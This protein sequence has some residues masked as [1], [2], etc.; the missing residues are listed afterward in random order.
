MSTQQIDSHARALLDRLKHVLDLHLGK[1]AGNRL[2]LFEYLPEDI[3]LSIKQQGLLTPFLPAMYGGVN[4]QRLLEEVLRLAG[5][6]G[7]SVT[8][9]VGIEGALVVQPLTHYGSPELVNKVLPLILE[10]TGGGL[11]ITEPDV[12]GSAIARNMASWYEV[13]EDG[14]LRIQAT[15]YWQGNSQNEFL[16]VAAKEK[17]NGKLQKYINLIFV[18]KSHIRYVPLRSEGLH[19]VRYAVNTIEGVLP[20]ENLIVLSEVPQKNLREFQSLFIRSRLQFIG[21]THG[22]IERVRQTLAEQW[23]PDIDFVYREQQEI[24]LRIQVSQLLYNFVCDHVSPDTAVSDRLLEANVIKSLGS[25]ITYEAALIAQKLMGA[26]GYEE[27]HSVSQIVRDIRPFTLF[28]GPN[29]MLS[30]EI[31]DQFSRQ[32]AAE[33]EAGVAVNKDSSLYQRYLSDNRFVY[34]GDK[35]ELEKVSPVISHFLQQNTLSAIGSVQKVFAGRVLAKL[36]VLGRT[37]QQT[38]RAFL[39]REISKDILNF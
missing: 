8:L 5:H 7:A 28:E 9:R 3:W 36:F 2:S 26:K 11:A 1:E 19:A 33:K 12:S 34:V 14:R 29:D 21:M 17:K 15:K 39:I 32:T 30:S 31:F 13:L 27:G 22:V 20:A 35:A 10:G 23:L 38:V 18:P 37:T 6:Y 16:L 4:N 25:Q 24:A